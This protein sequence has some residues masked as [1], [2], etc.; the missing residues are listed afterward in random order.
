MKRL[1]VLIIT[2]LTAGCGMTYKYA[3]KDFTSEDAALAYQ[4]SHLDAGVSKLQPS[5]TKVGGTLKIYFPDQDVARAKMITGNNQS[6]AAD[7]VLK[8]V[9]ADVKKLR[10]ALER[11]QAFDKVVLIFSKGEHQPA[12]PPNFVLYQYRQST[13]VGSWYFVGSKV[14][15]TPV[16]YDF[17]T[18]DMEARYRFF[19]E[20]VESLAMAEKLARN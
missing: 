12:E 18:T 13:S 16:T 1:L 5:P 8:T 6:T 7:Y 20:T 9:F 17:G 10:E 15:R 4:Q 11:R 2:L 19:V 14:P 3:G